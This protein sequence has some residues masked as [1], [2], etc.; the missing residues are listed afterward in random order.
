MR[1]LGLLL[2]ASGFIVLLGMRHFADWVR[3]S[4]AFFI[5]AGIALVVWSYRREMPSADGES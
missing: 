5:V 3:F 2:L 4:G 1:P